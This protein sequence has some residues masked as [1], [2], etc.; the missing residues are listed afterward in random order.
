VAL[1]ATHYHQG[2]PG[3]LRGAGDA[4][5]REA[6]TS[7]LLGADGRGKNVFDPE[8]W[9]TCN[10]AC[11]FRKATQTNFPETALR[12]RRREDPLVRE[13]FTAAAEGQRG[14]RAQYGESFTTLM[15]LTRLPP[16]NNAASGRERSE[17]RGGG[18]PNLLKADGGK[19]RRC[20]RGSVG[21]E[22]R[23]S[24]PGA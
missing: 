8:R 1:V 24:N 15:K 18:R 3:R 7:S 21:H 23:R 11:P 10:W 6:E 4:E 9:R 5:L 13:P 14:V 17:R 2:G 16:P 20:R 19:R 12:G 22:H